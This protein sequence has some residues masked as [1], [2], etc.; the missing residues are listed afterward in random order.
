MNKELQQ[1]QR[2]LK[3][4]ALLVNPGEDTDYGIG[5]YQNYRQKQKKISYLDNNNESLFGKDEKSPGGL[6]EYADLIDQIDKVSPNNSQSIVD[7]EQIEIEEKD[8]S[9]SSSRQ[10]QKTRPSTAHTTATN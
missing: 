5:A 6:E 1:L 8:R 10:K 7:I 3:D 2:L 4:E 9:R